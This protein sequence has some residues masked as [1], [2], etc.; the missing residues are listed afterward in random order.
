MIVASCIVLFVGGLAAARPAWAGRDTAAKAGAAAG[1]AA[2]GSAAAPEVVATVGGVPLTWDEIGA[3][4]DTMGPGT[5]EA[6]PREEAVARSVFM[7]QAYEVARLADPSLPPRPRPLADCAAAAE[8]WFN[9]SLDTAASEEA[10][11]A[12]YA[13]E[14]G[15]ARAEVRSRHILLRTEAE[16]KDALAAL[17]G[18]QPF[19]AVAR[20]RSQDPGSA[21]SGGELGWAP[22]EVFVPAFAEVL[23]TAPVGKVTGPVQS[24]FGW[25]LVEV[26]GRRTQEP[27]ESARPRIDAQLREERLAALV[28]YTEGRIPASIVGLDPYTRLRPVAAS[29]LAGLPD[30]AHGADGLRVVVFEDLACPHCALMHERLS[31]LHDGAPDLPVLSR[32]YPLSSACNPG[33][34]NDLHPTACAATAWVVCAGDAGPTLEDHMFRAQDRV[35]AGEMAALAQEAGLDAASLARCAV[36]PTPKAAIAADVAAA[37]A[38]GLEGTPTVYVEAQGRWYQYTGQ[39]AELQP[40]LAALR[41]RGH[42]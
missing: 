14:A 20:E 18:G 12:R 8:A 28:A 6:V 26:E 5:R 25:H 13:R 40:T 30:Q 37:E 33:V 32:F 19:E 7:V 17:Q 29:A 22:P 39:G 31:G 41:E 24:D 4:L 42:R 35:V 38:L 15:R 9:G 3:W 16:A 10:I 11:Q 36:G 23:R 1:S 2:R 27:F 34:E 21:G